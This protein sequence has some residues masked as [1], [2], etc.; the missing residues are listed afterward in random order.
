MGVLGN[1]RIKDRNSI[2]SFSWVNSIWVSLINPH[3]LRGIFFP[4]RSDGEKA[5]PVE[6]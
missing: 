5:L 4:G 2:S 6:V 3:T 1:D